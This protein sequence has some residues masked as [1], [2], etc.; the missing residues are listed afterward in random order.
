MI[1]IDPRFLRVVGLG[2]LLSLALLVVLPIIAA[3]AVYFQ[4][5]I[6]K[7]YRDVRKT[8]SRIT[9]AFNEG[10]A[11]AKTTKTLVR[12]DANT[13][14]F[15]ELTHA[16]RTHSVRAAVLSAAF[17]GV[18]LTLLFKEEIGAEIYEEALR[19]LIRGVA[20]QLAEPK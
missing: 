4:K 14:E 12:E 18:F 9:G 6:L 7:S 1:Q 8:N 5:R 20:M 16:M 17:R 19:V 10:I 2:L 13:Q 3:L 11:G 15:I